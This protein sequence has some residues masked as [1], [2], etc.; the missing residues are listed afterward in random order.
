MR[1]P[2]GHKIG[3]NSPCW[4]G[5]HHKYK[6]CHMNGDLRTQLSSS[7]YGER[8]R[9]RDMQRAKECFD[10][11]RTKCMCLCPPSLAGE[12]SSNIVKAHT[13][14]RSRALAAIAEDHRVLTLIPSPGRGMIQGIDHYEPYEIATKHASA[15]PAFCAHHD[16][17]FFASI[18]DKTIGPTHVQAFFFHY[19]AECRELYA[20]LAHFDEMDFMGTIGPQ[21]HGD[22][23]IMRDAHHAADKLNVELGLRDIKRNKAE[24]DEI[25]LSGSF[26]MIRYLWFSFRGEPA[27]VAAGSTYP[28]MDFTGKRLQHLS[29]R[30][31]QLASVSF[32]CIPI[33]GGTGALL[34]WAPSADATA[35]RLAASL[36]AIPDQHKADA[37]FRFAFTHIANTYMRI[38]WW[39]SMSDASRS[40][41]RRLIDRGGDNTVTAADL[42]PDP[43]HLLAQWPLTET[44]YVP[45]DASTLH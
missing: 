15:M 20:K 28:L 12:C 8:E 41:V 5:S 10:K 27:F 1:D 3:R 29:D 2:G 22:A 33:E 16:K 23:R 43:D 42:S 24:L 44:K 9:I 31:L 45:G 39:E 36:L 34:G 7:E 35:S 26:H 38:S 18:E 4:C 25:L 17:K 32:T 21:L 30:W 40:L 6:Y 37:I 13:V 19:R 11:T 14:Q